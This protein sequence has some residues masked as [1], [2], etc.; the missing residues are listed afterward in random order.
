MNISDWKGSEWSSLGGWNVLLYRKSMERS[1]GQYRGINEYTMG[2]SIL[3]QQE[4]K[5]RQFLSPDLKK[6]MQL[7]FLAFP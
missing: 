1:E 3:M 5:A 7:Q 6:K 4:E 2:K